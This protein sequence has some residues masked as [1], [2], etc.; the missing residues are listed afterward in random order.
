VGVNLDSYQ[1]EIYNSYGAL[2]WSSIK[3]D[4]YGA[5]LEGWEGYYQD[6]NNTSYKCPQD[7]YVWKISAKFRDGTIWTNTD[8]GEHEGLSEPV[9]GTVTLIR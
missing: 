8:V 6:N 1:C 3:L 5:P 9:W 7:V 4:S 2:V